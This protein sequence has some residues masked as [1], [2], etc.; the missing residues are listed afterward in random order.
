EM[1]NL[2]Q[3][4]PG[5]QE[6]A[7]T[8]AD[9]GIYKSGRTI[10][11]AGHTLTLD[12]VNTRLGSH[13][14]QVE[15]RPFISG[16]SFWAEKATGDKSVV[17][18]VNPN[19]ETRFNSIYAG[20]Y[21]Y[22][23]NIPFELKLG[24]KTNYKTIIDNTIHTGGIMNNYSGDVK[25]TIGGAVAPTFDYTK[26]TGNTDVEVNYSQYLGDIEFNGLRTLTLSNQAYVEVKKDSNFEVENLVV[27]D[28]SLLDLKSLNGNPIVNG[29]F[30]GDDTSAIY[31]NNDQTLKVNNL[32]SGSIRLNNHSRIPSYTY[33]TENHVF[34]SANEN[35]TMKLIICD[36][37]IEYGLRVWESV[38][39]GIKEYSL[40]E[41]IPLTGNVT[42]SG[43]PKVGQT[44]TANIENNQ[45]DANLSYQWFANG[46]E[47]NGATQSTL[48][49]TDAYIGQQ[50]SVK[51]TADNYIGTLE[52]NS[53]TVV[54]NQLAG[55]VTISG[56][57]KV[58][59]ILTANVANNQADANLSYQW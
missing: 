3:I 19:S 38:N 42:I 9:E 48:D 41:A 6:P 28:G 11:V 57:P 25:I 24:E 45:A 47:I 53:V 16:G 58:G 8:P 20:D 32:A 30:T 44:L 27:K 35:S 23:S 15:E 39:N 37:D 46:T 49:L 4:M 10:Y 52:S 13:I 56:T 29:D 26:H 5:V 40:V 59:Q 34:L 7:P 31:L 43:T 1:P 18:I 21:W 55:T 14:D 51:V 50:I 36:E 2:N 22:E 17:N 12:N 54:T 33:S